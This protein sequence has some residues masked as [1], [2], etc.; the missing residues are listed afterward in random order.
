MNSS[1]KIMVIE[2]RK[3]DTSSKNRKIKSL[4]LMKSENGYD[5]QD[6]ELSYSEP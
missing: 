6:Y 4:I 2:G 1:D 5:K 3:Q